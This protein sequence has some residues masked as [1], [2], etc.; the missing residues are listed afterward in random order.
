MGGLE[1]K[2]MRVGEWAATGRE[3]LQEEEEVVEVAAAVA[4]PVQNCRQ[5]PR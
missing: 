5:E 4:R 3:G 2:E 1:E